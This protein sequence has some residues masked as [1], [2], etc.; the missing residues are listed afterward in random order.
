MSM[1]TGSSG[2]RRFDGKPDY[3]SDLMSL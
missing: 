1:L 3:R 2:T